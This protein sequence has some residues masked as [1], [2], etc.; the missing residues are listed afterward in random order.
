[1]E[2]GVL[3]HFDIS[4]YLSSDGCGNPSL[5]PNQTSFDPTLLN[6]T[7][8]VS[9]INKLGAKYGTLVAKHVCGFTT[10]P[11][12]VTFP[13]TTDNETIA[14]NY[15]IAQSPVSGQNVVGSFSD[16]AQNNNLGHGFYYSLVSNN[17]LR[18]FNDAVDDSNIWVPGQVNITDDTF[19]QVWSDQVT[20]L[21]TN[22]GTL[23]E[24]GAL[25]KNVQSSN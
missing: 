7:Q 4:T 9:T 1:M 5:L 15:T 24:V 21:W 16:S 25:L 18:V 22:Y 13:T 20:D 3:I 11:S 23:T 14:Y 19:A 2:I 8:W 17:F 6:T 12:N 10:W